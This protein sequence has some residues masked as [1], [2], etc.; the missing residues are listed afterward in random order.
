MFIASWNGEEIARSEPCI[1]VENSLYFP[2][3]SIQPGALSLGNGS[4]QCYW[5]GGQA[6]GRAKLIAAHARRRDVA[7]EPPLGYIAV[8]GSALPAAHQAPLYR[9]GNRR[10]HPASR[11]AYRGS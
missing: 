2:P 3:H 5:K 8:W 10:S 11:R 1:L 7:G 9:R 4:S 6:R